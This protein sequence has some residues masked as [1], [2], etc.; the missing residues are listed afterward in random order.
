MEIK[1]KLLIF[2]ILI[3]TF[4]FSVTFATLYAQSN[5]IGG[6]AESC[7]LP[8]PLLIPMFSSFGILV[9]LISFYLL[10]PK[11][12]R[13]KEELKNWIE[14]LDPLENKIIK[15]II[16]NDGRITQAK[17]SKEIGKVKA[18]RVLEKLKARGVI[19]KIKDRKTNIIK[20]SNKFEF[21]LKK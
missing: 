19:E 2:G 11:I 14:L 1:R 9:G 8:I 17:I 6:T 5:I 18:F 7:T 3:S 20:L 16:E 10:L 4:I 21:L 12:E 15:M 13:N